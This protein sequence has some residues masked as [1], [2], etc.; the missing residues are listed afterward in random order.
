MRSLLCLLIA[1][2]AG[3]AAAQYGVVGTKP[4]QIFRDARRTCS[5]Y[6]DYVVVSANHE[7]SL[8]QDIAVFPASAAE[9]TELCWIMPRDT[10]EFRPVFFSGEPDDWSYFFGMLG[11]YLFIDS[12]S[13]PEDRGLDVY[14]VE[15]GEAVYAG[16]YWSND[17]VE[18]VGPDRITFYLSLWGDQS[19]R[20]CPEAEVEEWPWYGFEERVELDLT[21]GEVER[22]GEVKC[23]YRM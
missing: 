20:S 1:L 16:S 15:T 19:E 14:D 12:G 6:D 21:T 7:N 10:S 4:R 23:S 2:C 11:P 13:G 22:T 5:V 18:T 3:E 9:T 17:A 8:G